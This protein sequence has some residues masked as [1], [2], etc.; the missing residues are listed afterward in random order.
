MRRPE[1]FSR[2]KLRSFISWSWFFVALGSVVSSSTLGSFALFILLGSSFSR[3]THTR[4][5]FRRCCLYLN[6]DHNVC[7]LFL[8]EDNPYSL[9]LASGVSVHMQDSD[10][11]A[12]EVCGNLKI[13]N[14]SDI[15]IPQHRTVASLPGKRN[16]LLVVK[17]SMLVQMVA[18][19]GIGRSERASISVFTSDLDYSFPASIFKTS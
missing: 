9:C 17:R 2:R 12:L 5:R 18:V 6:D 15:F 19:K 13:M 7:F 1:S 11:K 8:S 16:L 14:S 4:C 10:G 3:G